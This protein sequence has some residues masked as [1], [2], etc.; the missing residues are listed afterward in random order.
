MP[1]S[2]N[3]THL[4]HEGR[5]IYIVGTAHISKDSVH[6]VERVIEELSP[7]TV[8]I[9]LDRMRY[10]TL[11]D[12]S[13]WQ[14]LDIFEVI[15]Q[16]K[17]L[18]LMTSL[19]LSAYQRRMGE[20]L[21]VRPGAEMLKAAELAK[22]R[23]AKL[24]LA[25]RNIQATLKRTWRNVS[26]TNKLKLIASLLAGFFAASKITQEQVEEM[27]DRD[28]IRE[29]M[30]EFAKAMP[31]VQVP[32]IDE[33]D[34]YLMSSIEEAPGQTVVAVVGAGH[35]AGMVQYLGEPVD[36]K[37]LEEI[38]PPAPGVNALKWV[39]PSI[40]LGAFVYGYFKHEGD[41]FRDMIYAWVLPNSIL[42]ALF[43]IVAAARPLTVLVAFVA[44]PITS[45]NPTIA[46]GM[47][48]GLVEAWLRKPTVD[49]CQKVPEDAQTLRGMYRNRFT[50]VLLVAVLTTIGS[51]LAGWIG[52]GW[53]V[54]LL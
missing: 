34:R 6:E 44:S 43:A 24:V 31:E 13:R 3:V 51:G 45:L 41:G 46:A 11:V 39:I 1:L 16:K 25:D 35:V 32:L 47:A 42:C 53:V 20:A 15:K 21:G 33:R 26:F 52:A 29:M 8:C 54:S 5:D 22:E 30:E 23:G 27:K 7:D 17:V 9:E 10:E 2:D 37:A 28:T 50:R 19:V 40:V 49:D 12:E 48:T 18:F 38:P 14:K 4:R 36:R